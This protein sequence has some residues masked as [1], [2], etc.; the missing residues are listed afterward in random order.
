MLS[1]QLTFKLSGNSIQDISLLEIVDIQE[2]GSSIQAH[3]TQQVDAELNGEAKTEIQSVIAVSEDNGG[4]WYFINTYDNNR[5]QL[6]KVFPQLN[7]K[8]QF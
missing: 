3:V 7:P 4:T 1:L 2:D 8:L 5:T 6:E